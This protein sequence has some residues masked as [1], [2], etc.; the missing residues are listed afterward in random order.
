MARPLALGAIFPQSETSRPRSKPH[1]VVLSWSAIIPDSLEVRNI[2]LGY[3]VYRCGP[4][5]PWRRLNS[6]TVL[7]TQYTDL[8]VHAGQT[9]FYTTRSV[10]IAGAESSPSNVIRVVIPFP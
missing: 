2:I 4:G 10:N 7:D 9:Y 3:N 5:R 6:D 8:R 1:R